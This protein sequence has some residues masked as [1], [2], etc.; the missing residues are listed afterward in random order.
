M[1]PYLDYT[2][3]KG[4][5]QCG[6]ENVPLTPAGTRRAP[7]LRHIYTSPFECNWV[8]S[9]LNL[10][11]RL[12]KANHINN[13]QHATRRAITNLNVIFVLKSYFFVK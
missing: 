1:F 13:Y 5:I 7:T 10:E 12:P 2:L 9:S 3:Y 6:A 8:D 4:S 11:E